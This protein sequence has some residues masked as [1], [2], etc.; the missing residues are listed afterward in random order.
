MV[1]Q[2]GLSDHLGSE[3]GCWDWECAVALLPAAGASHLGGGEHFLELGLGAGGLEAG[4]ALHAFCY[5]ERE[6]LFYA[7]TSPDHVELLAGTDLEH[8]G[9]L[10][11][12]GHVGACWDVCGVGIAEL[13]E[14][15]IIRNKIISRILDAL[16]D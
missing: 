12:D 16:Y 2:V 11:E 14:D 6:N 5:I 15:D 1:A 4:D 13:T 9:L 3:R 10:E 8:G 7:T